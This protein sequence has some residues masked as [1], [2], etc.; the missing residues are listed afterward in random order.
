MVK[1]EP[2]PNPS[3]GPVA[4]P[5]DALGALKGALAGGSGAPV[6]GMTSPNGTPVLVGQVYWGVTREDRTSEPVFKD[7]NTA[8][9][10]WYNWPQDERA[11]FAKRLYDAKLISDPTDYEAA[12]NKWLYAVS[13]S[14][15]FVAI[16]QKLTPWDVVGMMS[17]PNARAKD[18]NG[19]PYAN[20]TIT[21]T[22]TGVKMIDS[23]TAHAVVKSIFQSAVGRNPNAV[24]LARYGGL[25]TGYA[26]G[27]PTTRTTTTK[28]DELGSATDSS[29][30]ESGGYTDAGLNSALQDKVSQSKEYGSYQAATTYYNA[31]MQMVGGQGA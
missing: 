9:A 14:A 29:V 12:R 18:G 13:E 20:K 2:S 15:N 30:T 23:D 7:A 26:Q 5:G 28:H 3:S 4:V 10:D 1:F 6:A 22:A 27:H 19:S 16:G 24:E 17:D 21:T 8:A 25:I 31:L 11:A